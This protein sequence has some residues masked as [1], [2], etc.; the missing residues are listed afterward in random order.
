M[1]ALN[2]RARSAAALVLAAVAAGSAAPLQAQDLPAGST[3]VARYQEAVGGADALARYN[4]IHAVGE[5]AV[6]AQGLV[7]SLDSYSARPDRAA[8]VVS[9]AGFGEIRS[10]YTGADAWSLNPAEGPR[11]LQGAERTQAIEEA[12]FES[13]LRPAEL[14]TSATT[15]ER[16]KLAGRD[17]IKVRLVWKSGRETHDCY[18][19]ETGL[20]V[21][22]LARQE[23]HMGTIDAVTLFEDYREFGGITM[24]VRVVIQVMG[25]EQVITIRDVTFDSVPDSVFEPPAEIRALIGG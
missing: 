25:I 17:C 3:L 16:T 19:E 13:A 4:S 20:L 15:V 2:R 8:M 22:S 7:G 23:T 6:P 18:S 1:D 9:I 24:P 5:V 11:L 12:A 14:I 10:G 21:G